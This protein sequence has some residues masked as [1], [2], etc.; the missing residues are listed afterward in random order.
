MNG[1]YHLDYHSSSFQWVGTGYL[2][3]RRDIKWP[4]VAD[5]TTAKFQWFQ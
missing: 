3:I 1:F 5:G 4:V 2:N